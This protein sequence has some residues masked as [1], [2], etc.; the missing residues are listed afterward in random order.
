V[1]AFV[2][3]SEIKGC[4]NDDPTGRRDHKTAQEERQLF[5]TVYLLIIENNYV[6]IHNTDLKHSR[7]PFKLKT[8]KWAKAI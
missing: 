2:R 6:F 4:E 1:P 5:A 8:P 7:Y 3:C